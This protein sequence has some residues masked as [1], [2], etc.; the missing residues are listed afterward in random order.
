MAS[1]MRAYSLVRAAPAP[2][3]VRLRRSRAGPRPLNALSRSRSTELKTRLTL[4]ALLIAYLT[5][6]RR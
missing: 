2:A 3:G 4:I 6:S 1:T 5:A